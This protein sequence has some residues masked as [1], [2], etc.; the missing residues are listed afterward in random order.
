[1]ARS[2]AAA[3]SRSHP[4]EQSGVSQ[5]RPALLAR[6]PL[7]CARSSLQKAWQGLEPPADHAPCGR[8]SEQHVLEA[9]RV[10]PPC[11][12]CRFVVFVLAAHLPEENLNSRM[13]V[14]GAT[15]PLSANGLRAPAGPLPP[16]S[17]T[18]FEPRHPDETGQSPC[19][20]AR[21][22]DRKGAMRRCDPELPRD[23]RHVSCSTFLWPLH[24]AM[25]NPLHATLNCNRMARGEVRKGSPD[26]L[27]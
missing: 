18:S 10:H 23:G 24:S 21:A 11:S 25:P 26:L 5:K 6:Q 9:A 7:S 15:A 14:R 19:A 20:C 2:T 8:R 16:S 4:W 17:R 22:E 27:Y 1:M 12:T 13:G 3:W